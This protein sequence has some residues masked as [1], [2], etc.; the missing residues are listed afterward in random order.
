MIQI[1]FNTQ[2][3]PGADPVEWVIDN[4]HRYPVTP[5]IPNRMIARSTQ[6]EPQWGSHIEW[7]GQILAR[8]LVPRDGTY[9]AAA[10]GM[11]PPVLTFQ[12]SSQPTALPSIVGDH[13]ELNGNRWVWRMADGFCD[14][15]LL[16]TGN[17]RQVR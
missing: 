8:F 11:T 1:N 10:I 15:A 3:S 14:H 16:F 4:A 5:D 13:F 6:P 7:K 12:G 2:G 9:E 17:V